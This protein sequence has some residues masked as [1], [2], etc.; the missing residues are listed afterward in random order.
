MKLTINLRSFQKEFVAPIL[1]INKDGKAAI[2]VK[3]NLLY[4]ISQTSDNRVSLYNTYSPFNIEDP[5]PRFNVNLTRLTKALTCLKKAESVSTFNIQNN[6]LSYQDDLLKFNLKLLD[7]NL[8]IDPKINPEAID[9]F[10]FTTEIK[11]E[12]SIMSELKR[13][14]DF[15][16]ETEKFY[17]ELEGNKLY[18]LF[19]DKSAESAN[20]HDDIKILISDN[21]RGE[22]PSNIFNINI[23]KLLERAN[24]D[25]IFKLGRNALIAQFQRENSNYQYLT[26]SLKK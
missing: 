11:V 10:P 15:S 7:Q 1:E 20:V 2:F 17:I 24:T 8:L 19:G 21:F 3:D 16:S 4:S 5:L 13:V 12:A 6:N 26:T 14:L 22:I 23:L 18:F 9:R 25:V